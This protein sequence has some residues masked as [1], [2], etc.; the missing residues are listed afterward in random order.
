MSEALNVQESVTQHGYAPVP[1]SVSKE[2]LAGTI[3]AYL[4]FLEL[5]ADVQEATVFDLTDR[6]DG[7]F[8]QFRRL[9]GENSARGKRPD[10]KDVFHFGSMTRQI[11]EARLSGPLPK[12][13]RTFMD[14]AEAVYWA[15]QRT[16]RN[17]LADL[18]NKGLMGA[19]VTERGTINDVL[20]LIAYYPNHGALAKGH[21]DRSVSTLAIGESHEGLRMAPAQNGLRVDANEDYMAGVEVS[22]Q[23]VEH[24]SGEAK[25]FLG[26]GWNR[27]PTE[28]RTGN[29]DLPLAYHDVVET[30][31]RVGEKVMRW[32][33]VMFSNPQLDFTDYTV[34]SQAETR[35]YKQL[36]KL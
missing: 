16:K 25:F 27:L 35:P 32:A 17:A 34:P 30:G 33:I 28:L 14:Q 6:G 19:M 5:P 18:G 24:H 31:K 7:D 4:N 9:P 22:L 21:F 1:I 10:N 3:G 11:T 29:E 8:G 15:A 23:P 26:S 2:D 13:L 20:R 12:D 36:G